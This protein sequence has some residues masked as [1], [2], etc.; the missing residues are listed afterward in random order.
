MSNI[1][2][3]YKKRSVTNSDLVKMF[4]K[5]H[6]LIYKIAFSEK[7]LLQNMIKWTSKQKWL[8]YYKANPIKEY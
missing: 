7:K 3:A 8:I 6:D 1:S 5:L 4:V 2:K